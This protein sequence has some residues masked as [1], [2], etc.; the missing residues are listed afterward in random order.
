MVQKPLTRLRVF[1][2]LAIIRAWCAFSLLSFLFG[3]WFLLM[4]GDNLLRSDDPYLV[5][6]LFGGVA[7]VLAIIYSLAEA[8]RPGGCFKDVVW[9]VACSLWCAALFLTWC[10]CNGGEGGEIALLVLTG[11]AIT[12]AVEWP[13]LRFRLPRRAIA[14]VSTVGVSMISLYLYVV[15][16]VLM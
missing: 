14:V 5:G 15:L 6:F 4:D 16:V 8:V 10:S 9:L 3:C 1:L 12:A 2:R 11:S 7:A 13:L